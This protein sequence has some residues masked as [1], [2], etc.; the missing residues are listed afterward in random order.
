MADGDS[1]TLYEHKPGN[2]QHH[3][4]PIADVFSIVARSNNC[5]LAVADGVNWGIKPRLAARCAIHGAMEH[6][7]MS[8][9]NRKNAPHTV[10]DIFHCILRSFHSGQKL[11]IKHGGT[12]TTLSVAVVVE[13]QE[14]KGG[15][16]W[17]LCVV[18]VGDS[19]CFVWREEVQMVYE[20][21]SA[22][23]VGKE[24]NPRD[25]GGCLGCDLGDQPDLSN[26]MCC[27]VP[28]SDEDI[29]FIVSDGVSDNSDPV[30]LK[31]ALAEGQ[32]LSPPITPSEP[33]QT[34][35]MGGAGAEHQGEPSSS[36]AAPNP[37]PNN[38]HNHPPPPP[39]T[40]PLPSLPTVSP[41]QRQALILMKLTNVLKSKSK[42]DKTPLHAQDVRDAI[43]NHVI[44]A[45]E[46]KR[47]YLERCWVELEKPDI[48]VS[49]RRANERKIAQ[50]IKTMPG[51]LDHATVAAYKVGKRQWEPVNSRRS[52]SPTRKGGGEWRE[53]GAKGYH[54][55]SGSVF[56]GGMVAGSKSGRKKVVARTPHHQRVKISERWL[57]KGR[58]KGKGGVARGGEGLQ[59][60]K[61]QSYDNGWDARRLSTKPLTRA[62]TLE[63]FDG[64]DGQ[65][66]EGVELKEAVDEGVGL[67]EASGLEL[68]K[69]KG[70]GLKEAAGVY[71][72]EGVG[73]KEAAGV[74]L[75]EGVGLK[76]AA[77]IDLDKGVGLEEAAEVDL[78]KGVGLEE[79]AEV[80]LDEGVG[81]EKGS[82]LNKEEELCYL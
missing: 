58:G 40:P 18:S 2:T 19:L 69:G 20:I 33:T 49:E 41:E 38:T 71:L 3:G 82:E 57:L 23:H 35:G 80:D 25:C 72:D 55:A 13:L 36:S 30:I 24:R 53:G 34:A 31:E 10:Q 21:T 67:K 65:E 76:E 22:M 6:L 50:H 11:I 37:L 16:R 59:L 26:L 29:V 17:G 75:D 45:T 39:P 12:T 28:L 61:S 27:F 14:P 60:K 52:H 47:E 79:A 1:I 68:D 15:A 77:G 56:Y 62:S 43:I 63:Y 78:D 44:E 7:N 66:V 46:M 51:K 73:L 8:L 9:F 42:P 74:N 5:I 48:T 54:S 81:L 64:D 4:D 32:P 70:V